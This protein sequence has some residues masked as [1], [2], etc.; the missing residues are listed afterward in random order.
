MIKVVLRKLALR[1]VDAKDRLLCRRMTSA[2]RE[3]NL[4]GQWARWNSMVYGHESINVNN[5]VDTSLFWKYL[6]WKTNA[7]VCWYDSE[8]RAL[9]T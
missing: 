3:A 9:S 4:G 8:L 2:M 7:Y 5:D 1:K 6:L